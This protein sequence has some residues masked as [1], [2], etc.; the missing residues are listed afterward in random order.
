[1]QLCEGVSSADAMA[2]LDAVTTPGSDP[3]AH[4]V[5]PF[6]EAPNA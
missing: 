4:G 3:W 2:R 6:P 1:M 5:E